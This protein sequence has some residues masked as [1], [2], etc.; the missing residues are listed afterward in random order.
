MN[1]LYLALGLLAGMVLPVQASINNRLGTMFGKE[2]L[3]AS[4]ISFFV[5]ALVLGVLVLLRIDNQVISQGFGNMTLADSWK[6]VGGAM[7]AFFV[8]TSIFL[9][10]KIGVA[11]MMF[12]FILG[13][14]AMAMLIDSFGLIGM[15][16]QSVHWT[17]I[18]GLIAMVGSVAFFIMGKKWFE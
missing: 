5:G 1:Y 4:F 17:K 9:S 7:G 10:P 8:F 16:V 3:F 2:P 15:P 11:N 18:V 14:L 12:L 6:W 13:Q